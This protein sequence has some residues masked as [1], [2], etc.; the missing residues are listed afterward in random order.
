ADEQIA[1][2]QKLEYMT[3]LEGSE[4]AQQRLQA[5]SLLKD[6]ITTAADMLEKNLY[7]TKTKLKN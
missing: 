1:E 2:L 6:G 4:E 5:Y 7:S 3:P